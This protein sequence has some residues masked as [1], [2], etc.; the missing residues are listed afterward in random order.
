MD[1]IGHENTL[2]FDKQLPKPSWMDLNE[3]LHEKKPLW[4]LKMVP[5]FK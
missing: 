5:D 3:G 2:K 4:G 1:T